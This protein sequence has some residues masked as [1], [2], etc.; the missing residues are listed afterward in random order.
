MTD[1]VKLFGEDKKELVTE[2]KKYD[3]DIKQLCLN[4]DNGVCIYLASA[5]YPCK[6]ICNCFKSANTV[7]H[8]RINKRLR[9]KNKLKINDFVTMW[10]INKAYHIYPDD[11]SI[12]GTI[13]LERRC[14]N[15]AWK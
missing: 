2:A 1:Q 8:N 14:K 7:L 4:N 12:Q 13:G 9:G 11:V 3:P 5:P 10:H 15:A 6:E